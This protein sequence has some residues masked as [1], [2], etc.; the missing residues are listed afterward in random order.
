[1]GFDC[2]LPLLE[3]IIDCGDIAVLVSKRVAVQWIYESHDRQLGA[4]V[5][6][7]RVHF[8]EVMSKNPRRQLLELGQAVDV[9]LQV[10]GG[11]EIPPSIL[12]ERLMSGAA[13]GKLLVSLL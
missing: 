11:T 9:K 10:D 8:V 1:M 4:Q 2:H 3:C 12:Q 6:P 13:N 5:S 7:S